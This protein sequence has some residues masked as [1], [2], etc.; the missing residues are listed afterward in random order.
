MDTTTDDAA[1]SD[2]QASDARAR[3]ARDDQLVADRVSESGRRRRGS[4]I[5][6]SRLSHLVAGMVLGAAVLATCQA[7]GSL[8][9]TDVGQLGAALES[10]VEV[11]IREAYLNRAIA[12]QAALNGSPGPIQNVRVDLQP[13]QRVEL[14][15][16]VSFMNQ[17]LVGTATGLLSVADG[18]MRVDV[19]GVQVGS[20]R[21]PV[22]LG[23]LVSEPINAELDRLLADGQFRI[24]GVATTTDRLIVRLAVPA[25]Q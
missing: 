1:A 13:Q 19:D 6:W 16:D 25:S 18:R 11:S 21:L 4:G 20:L 17:Q 15:A 10:D 14:T 9:P 7:T 12:E 3:T 22:G 2:A 5:P 8:P 23:E 24:A